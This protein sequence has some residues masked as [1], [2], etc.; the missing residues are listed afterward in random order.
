[1]ATAKKTALPMTLAAPPSVVSQPAEARLD[2]AALALLLERADEGDSAAA[3]T[4]QTLLAAQ[5]VS[6]LAAAVDGI[7]PLPVSPNQLRVLAHGIVRHLIPRDARSAVLAGERLWRASHGQTAPS[8]TAL[9]SQALQAW[10]STAPPGRHGLVAR[11][12]KCRHLRA[13]RRTRY[14]R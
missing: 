10:S 1:M 11:H 5:P 3:R 7:P 8:L 4:A 12:G 13:A 14:N 2:L 9:V 6:S